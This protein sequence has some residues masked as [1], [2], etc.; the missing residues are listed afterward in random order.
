M[1]RKVWANLKLVE[2]GSAGVHLSW[3]TSLKTDASDQYILK[4]WGDGRWG[5]SYRYSLYVDGVKNMIVCATTPETR[6]PGV[7]GVLQ[8]IN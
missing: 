2:D 5:G 6:S 7:V 1:R 8:L 3:V 4:G